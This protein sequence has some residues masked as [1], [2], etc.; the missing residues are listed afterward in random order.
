[1]R[2]WSKAQGAWGQM[3]LAVI[4]MTCS[5]FG[6]TASDLG[7]GLR[8]ELTNTPGVTAIKWWGKSGRT[9]FVQ[10]SE[11]LLPDSWQFMP[12]VEAGADAVCTW[13]LQ[14]SASKMFVR[15]VFTDQAFSGG[16]A[17]ADFDGD[18]LT[19]AQETAA[20]GPRSN[21]LSADSDDDGYLDGDEH[22]MGADPNKADS[23]PQPNLVFF[24]RS[25][26]SAAWKTGFAPFTGTSD[27]RYTTKTT[28]TNLSQMVNDHGSV[29]NPPQT[30]TYE[31]HWSSASTTTEAWAR[32]VGTMYQTDSFTGL[33]N[34]DFSANYDWRDEWREEIVNTSSVGETHTK[35]HS[36][37]V[38]APGDFDTRSSGHWSLK[39]QADSPAVTGSWDVRSSESPHSADPFFPSPSFNTTAAVRTTTWD[40]DVPY[41]TSG[42]GHAGGGGTQVE[43]LSGPTAMSAVVGALAGDFG[44]EEA[45]PPTYDGSGDGTSQLSLHDVSASA[46]ATQY[47]YTL[48]WPEGTPERVKQT[49]NYPRSYLIQE[50]YR[51]DDLSVEK[52]NYKPITLSPGESSEPQLLSALTFDS[53]RSGLAWVGPDDHLLATV[54]LAVPA[55]PE[56]PVLAAAG[57]GWVPSSATGAVDLNVGTV[58]VPQDKKHTEGGWVVLNFDDDSNRGNYADGVTSAVPDFEHSGSITD[59]NDMI[60]VGIRKVEQGTTPV[61]YRFKFDNEHVRLWT[62]KDRSGPVTSEETLITIPDGMV[63][64]SAYVEG[65]KAHNDDNGTL[66]TGQVK[67]GDAPWADAETVKVRVARP[68]LCLWAD[69]DDWAADIDLLK[70]Y[71]TEQTG[72]DQS[73]R[74]YLY[75]WRGQRMGGDTFLLAGKNDDGE[76][77]CYSVTGAFGTDTP[78][79]LLKLGL[80]TEGMDIAVTGH[81]NYGVGLAF[82]KGFTSYSQF[83]NMAGG[84]T[85]AV[86]YNAFGNHTEFSILDPDVTPYSWRPAQMA[87]FTSLAVPAP[88]NRALQGIPIQNVARFPHLAANQVPIGGLFPVNSQFYPVVVPSGEI[89]VGPYTWHFLEDGLLTGGG[90]KPVPSKNTILQCGSHDV[91]AVLKYRSL[92]LN[93]CNSLRNFAESFQHGQVFAAWESVSDNRYNREF[94]RA[95]IDGKTA[96]GVLNELN[97]LARPKHPSNSLKELYELISY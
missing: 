94:V 57:N 59:E 77:V 67:I 52:K 80:K 84:G 62:G 2:A 85:T 24:H 39:Q 60:R 12:V 71:L 55:D 32:G 4:M 36:T 37:Q 3:M 41:G 20:V 10:S 82:G 44:V 86:A 69:L 17:D 11:T 73:K 23:V 88:T 93:A 47:Y 70:T 83:F 18:G 6:Q 8:A 43:T 13:N 5:A 48:E 29:E 78:N 34:D 49:G 14:T 27:T 89:Q 65:I 1:M 28:V 46:T 15:L 31:R 25:A 51:S 87:L 53:S 21:P 16:A 74:R 91:P 38:T 19:N 33:W 92:M 63:Y 50:N 22:A 61:S 42:N 76:D 68:I 7:E 96:S 30:W 26:A 90:V 54:D 35:W 72:N 79:R 58:L 75:A 95:I 97:K 64:A 45:W 66:I 56:P 9:Y 81:A 40:Q